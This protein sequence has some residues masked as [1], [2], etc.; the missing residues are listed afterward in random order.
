MCALASL[1]FC[2]EIYSIVSPKDFLFIPFWWEK[3]NL[4]MKAC[5]AII[6]RIWESSPSVFLC[7][8]GPFR[9][10]ITARWVPPSTPLS[11]HYNHHHKHSGLGH[12]WQTVLQRQL[13]IFF[14]EKNLIEFS[15]NVN[16][17]GRGSPLPV[18]FNAPP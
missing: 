4:E 3:K 17:E 2:L 7:V 8:L 13:L 6:M 14:K 11:P 16:Q 10:L 12:Y 18:F 1:Y 15:L 9:R 5:L